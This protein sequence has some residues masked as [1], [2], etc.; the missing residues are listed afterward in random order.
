MARIPDE[1]LER[2][3]AEVSVQRL[4]EARGIALKRH[5]AD[6]IGL[7]PFHDDRAPSLV[8][9]PK[10]NLWHCLGAC[11]AGGSVVD[12]VMRAEGVSFRHAVE[13]LREGELP[14]G[15]PRARPVKRT[16]A[17][18]L[19]DTLAAE[20]NAQALLRRVIDFYHEALKTSPDA[21][22][23]LEHRG[24]KDAGLIERFRL[25][26]ANRTLGYRLPDRN[27]QAGAEVRAQLQSLGVLRES[28]HE[29][30]NGSLIIPV[31][32]AQGQVCE[33]YGRKV[34]PNLRKGTPQHLYLP[35]PH[36]G[37][38]NE[39][40]LKGAQEVIVC[41]S[42]IDALTF[43][44]AGYRNVTASYGTGGFTDAHLAAFQAH[45]A[46]RVLIAY[47]RDDAGDSAAKALAEKLMAQGFECYRVLF[48]KGMD[49]NEYAL[50]VTPAV[51]SLGLVIRK[52]QWLGQGKAPSRESSVIVADVVA[53]IV[54]DDAIATDTDA[55]PIL[56]AAPVPVVT[57]AA[58]QPPAPADTVAAQVSE[59]EVVIELGERRYRVRGLDKASGGEQ[60][61]VNVLVSKGEAFHVDALDLYAARQRGA[62]IAQAA[63]ELGVEADVI[64]RDLG[65]VLLKL[66][67]LQEERL[68]EA[69]APKAPIA[70]TDVERT[71]ALE[72][73]KS[74]DL[75][76]R[77]LADF[78]RCGVV[79][80]ETNKLVGYLACISR[81]LDKP[82]ALIIQ[83]TSAAGKSALM[84]AVLDLVP[85]EER[86]HYSAMTGQ[87]LFYMGER[88]LKHKVLAIA[89]EAGVEEASY[90]L[91][92]LQSQGELT[93]ASTGK[94]PQTGKLTTQEYRVEGPV[95]LFL[96]TTAIEV[97]EELL[98]RCLVMSVNE[99]RAQTEAIQARQRFEESLE[100]LLEANAREDI[101][102][103]HRNAQRL[104]QPLKV[105]N[106]YAEQLTFLSDRT[107]TRRDHRKYLALIRA[108][109]LLHQHQR[110][111]KSAPT[112]GGTVE[113]IE[114]TL[115]DIE[116]A[117]VL[118]H[119]VLG[120]TLDELPPQTRRLLELI[121]AMVRERTA[122]L[123]IVRSD[124]RFSRREV[125]EAT[126][127]GHT[128][129]KV[130]LRRLE[131]HE[132]V[133]AHRSAGGQRFAYELL[134]GGEGDTGDAFVLGLIDT[135]SLKDPDYD[136]NRSGVKAHRSAP[137]RPPVGAWSGGG[138]GG[139]IAE[140]LD[141]PTAYENDEEK[142]TK[143][144][145]PVT[146][147]PSH[148][149]A[150]SNGIDDT[151]T[152][153]RSA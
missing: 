54:A 97:D 26:F 103:L 125:R 31:L 117:N 114:A 41:E 4:V 145:L 6:L 66:E 140:T 124:Y 51:K 52:A 45:S 138:R 134:Y 108:V 100:G 113:Y 71:A 136:A 135:E 9:S 118:A 77:I 34:T 149:R 35:G 128:Q 120:R 13:L 23:Y 70:M 101:F 12:W 150:K 74:P 53:G 129:L 80:E 67:A 144:T 11:Q 110:E 36:R 37:V 50:K 146:P 133:I 104:L 56:A 61:K 151:P 142:S 7:C 116:T 64:K 40:G 42:L 92:L 94:D 98:N 75:L 152:A 47:D 48:P 22:A 76:S 1:T 81:K 63:H 126:G 105:V 8:V 46:R 24:L 33:V 112:R 5:G 102:K 18:K 62:Y 95:M 2:L 89:E 30:F 121:E 115:E 16:T 106:P 147:S 130:H 55:A 32:D 86:V 90:A 79:G 73:L 58:A 29:H 27:R 99:T 60:L 119:E 143:R 141:P 10:K 15:T 59:Q 107:R 88:D 38:F 109:A 132:Y 137:G 91:K 69:N 72:L 148:R 127:W 139:D 96:T 93:I 153:A 122:A 123:D 20:A 65:R 39:A 87:S 25:G 84:D 83:S 21:L 82:L 49:A 131:E 17:K 78:E 111:V 44:A 57:A 68:R 19:P 3:K 43:Y 14:A 85:E 28:G